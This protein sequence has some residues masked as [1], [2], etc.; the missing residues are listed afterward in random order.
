VGGVAVTGGGQEGAEPAVDSIAMD[1]AVNQS[2]LVSGCLQLQV[3][4]A[5]G[6]FA[7]PCRG[8]ARKL[9]IGDRARGPRLDRSTCLAGD[10]LR[11]PGDSFS[12]VTRA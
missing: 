8:V 4:I 3:E 6:Q 12:L 7:E 1:G 2:W 10:P 9:E 5:R 11:L